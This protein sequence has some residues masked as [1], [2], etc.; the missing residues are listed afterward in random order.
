[1]PSRGSRILHG[2]DIAILE[3]RSETATIFL[4]SLSS[5]HITLVASIMFYT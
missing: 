5:R 2:T 1:M 4:G 3:M